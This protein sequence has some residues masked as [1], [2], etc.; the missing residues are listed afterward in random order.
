MNVRGENYDI[1]QTAERHVD[2]LKPLSRE[3]ITRSKCCWRITQPKGHD[4]TPNHFHRQ[5]FV[6]SPNEGRWKKS[7]VHQ[8]GI[9]GVVY[10][11]Q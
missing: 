1:V 10:L 6:N 8:K 3:S 7:T 5:L 2:H 9:N 11:Q 4:L